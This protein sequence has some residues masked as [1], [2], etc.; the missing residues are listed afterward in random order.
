MGVAAALVGLDKTG[1]GDFGQDAVLGE[2]LF[3]PAPDLEF[4]AAGQGFGAQG[5]VAGDLLRLATT[6][7]SQ[8]S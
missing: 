6:W 1:E 4:V 5:V 3:E 8:R 7:D 2:D